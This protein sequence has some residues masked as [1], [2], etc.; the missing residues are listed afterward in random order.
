[1]KCCPIFYS[2]LPMSIQFC[3]C[4]PKSFSCEF[5]ECRRSKGTSLK[6]VGEFLSLLYTFICHVGEIRHK[7][8]AHYDVCFCGFRD[9]H[10]GESCTYVC[11]IWKVEYTL[12][13][14]IP[15]ATLLYLSKTSRNNH[16]LHPNELDLFR[17]LDSP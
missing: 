7:R 6:N 14:R 1:M 5:H 13:W 2:N 8:V 15:F 16:P 4:L 12:V 17:Q 11:V 9:S 10:R 3:A